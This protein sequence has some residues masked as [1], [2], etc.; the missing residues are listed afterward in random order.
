LPTN[1]EGNPFGP[2][3]YLL[4]VQQGDDVRI[5]YDADGVVNYMRPVPLVT[6][7]GVS[8]AGLG[9][10]QFA[11]GFD[12]SGAGNGKRLTGTAG[13][14]ALTGTEL[15]DI[16]DGGD[17][18]DRLTGGAGNDRLIGGAGLDTAVYADGAGSYQ[19][20]SMADGWAIQDLRTGLSDGH[21][22]LTGIER[23]QF[24]DRA[25]AFDTAAAAGQ[26]YRLYKAAFDRVPD[27]RGLG[28]W[29]SRTDTGTSLKEIA[30][31]FINS[32]EFQQRYGGASNAD[33]ITR[34]YTNILHRTPEKGG[35]DYWVDVLDTKKA[36]L[37]SVLVAFSE[38]TENQAAVADIIARGIW[39][40]PWN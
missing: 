24:S 16:L 31:G 17:G 38:S 18:A 40:E 39:Y 2:L 4:A 6:L 8:L 27:E 20:L 37:A 14:D 9:A 36:D 23:V 26:T 19:R 10:S 32:S 21:D 15:D 7:G 30:G 22:T 33:I 3:S 28:Y 25:L 35:F 12:P 1:L 29:L 34:L 13:A 5:D 11:G